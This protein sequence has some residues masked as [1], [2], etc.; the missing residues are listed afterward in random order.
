M[1]HSYIPGH[2]LA[3]ALLRGCTFFARAQICVKLAVLLNCLREASCVQRNMRSLASN[4][5]TQA[6]RMVTRNF[7]AGRGENN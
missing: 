3:V 5:S 6:E 4:I 2:I 7:L 1:D